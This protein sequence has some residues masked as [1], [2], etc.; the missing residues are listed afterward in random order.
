MILE[1]FL[2][3]DYLRIDFSFRIHFCSF[4]FMLVNENKVFFDHVLQSSTKVIFRI[5]NNV[6]IESILTS[7]VSS[8]KQSDSCVHAFFLNNLSRILRKYS[9]YQI[10]SSNILQFD[11]HLLNFFLILIPIFTFPFSC[12]FCTLLGFD[13]N[14]LSE[15]C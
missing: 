12:S 3:I 9:A 8:N 7:F 2:I 4:Q 13:L 14:E 15:Y 10:N 6:I 5:A 1:K 11:L